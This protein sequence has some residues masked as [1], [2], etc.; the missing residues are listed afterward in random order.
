[1]EAKDPNFATN[2]GNF[3]YGRVGEHSIYTCL[4][5]LSMFALK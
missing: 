5:D 2:I 4:I 3:V 1:M